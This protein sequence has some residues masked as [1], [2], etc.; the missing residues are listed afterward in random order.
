MR[1][2]RNETPRDSDA[3]VRI[4]C[5]VVH[6]VN[7]LLSA[8]L[9]YT[10]LVLMNRELRAEDRDQIEQAQRA[11]LRAGELTERVLAFDRAAHPIALN[12][13]V[14][15]THLRRMLEH[16]AGR[17]VELI[18][19]FAPAL[20]LVKADPAEIDRVLFN[21]V[22]NSRDAMPHGGRLTLE[23]SDVW[24]TAQNHFLG[25]TLPAGGYVMLAAI[26]SGCGIAPAI[27]S[28]VFEPYFTTKAPG[29]GSGLGLAAVHAMVEDAGG[30]ITVRSEVGK[31]SAFRVYLPWH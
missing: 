7:N 20:H 17:E 14:A 15:I 18:T 12:L 29:K 5:G 24:L 1:T 19:T 25:T 10:Q 9:G 21:L 11:T 6:D 26:D 22:L 28:H 23:T 3:F 13:S 2:V 27:L 16:A 30:E 31:G 4:A 8:I